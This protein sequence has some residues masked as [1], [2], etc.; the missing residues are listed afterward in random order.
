MPYPN[1]STSSDRPRIA[2]SWRTA[3][4]GALLLLAQASTTWAQDGGRSVHAELSLDPPTIFQGQIVTIT[5]TI[6]A[7]GTTLGNEY[8]VTGL[9]P[10]H[11][12][13]LGPFRELPVRHEDSAAGSTE[14][15]QFRCEAEALEATT[16][17]LQP[18]LNFQHL[19]RERTFFGTT[20]FQSPDRT[21][22]APVT[23]SVRPVP[24]EG[25]PRDFS[26]QVGQ[27]QLGMLAQPQEVAVGDLVTLRMTLSGTGRLESAPCPTLAP[28]PQFKV[29][30]ARPVADGRPGER[31]FEQVVIPQSTNAVATPAAHFVF[32]DPLVAQF[33]T[34]SAGPIM[35]RHH[36][37]QDSPRFVPYHPPETAATGRPN[38]P[39]NWM[40]SD[41]IV[42]A[43]TTFRANAARATRLPVLLL[44]LAFVFVGGATVNLVQ[45]WRKRRAPGVATSIG[46]AL[47]LFA[48]AGIVAGAAYVAQQKAQ[49]RT[50]THVAA[51]VVTAHL[52]PSRT[53]AACGEIPEGATLSVTETWHGWLRVTAGDVRGWI[54]PGCA[55]SLTPPNHTP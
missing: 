21:P 37:R 14:V 32:F 18:T 5:L 43:E 9:P 13:R 19:T 4:L 51:R 20:T 36:V 7:R 10:D 40:R 34:V 15:H 6:R 28:D 31:V 1:H 53:A 52:A 17:P 27:F 50:P 39:P 8:S 47:L 11:L 2:A 44:L 42:G 30:P 35:L 3:A 38:S 24:T 12:F 46:R 26:G 29:Y 45:A 33:R 22:V 55:V 16:F 25:R 23:V 48:A 41:G 54:Q 49:E